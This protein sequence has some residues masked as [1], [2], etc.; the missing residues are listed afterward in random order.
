MN[1]YNLGKE[2]A[3]SLALR[4]GLS[5]HVTLAALRRGGATIRR[6]GRISTPFQLTKRDLRRLVRGKVSAGELAAE[7]KVR[8]AKLYGYLVGQGIRLRQERMKRDAMRATAMKRMHDAGASLGEIA[9]R[10]GLTR[11][12][13]RQILAK[14]KIAAPK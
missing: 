14:K 13:I 1:A 2:T 6:G 3:K 12:R 7:L 4:L 8:K 10:Y 11:E 9:M 5:H